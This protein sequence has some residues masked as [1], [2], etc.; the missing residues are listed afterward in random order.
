[1]AATAD[2]GADDR[3]HEMEAARI[4]NSSSLRE[5]VV[6]EELPR[7]VSLSIARSS[8]LKSDL[9]QYHAATD[10]YDLVIRFKGVTV[11]VNSPQQQAQS[12]ETFGRKIVGCFLGP[13]KL[14][15]KKRDQPSSV[16]V[17]DD[18]SGYV[19]PG[20]MT[21]VIGPAGSGKTALLKVLAGH[22]HPSK[23]VKFEGQ[24]LYNDSVLTPDLETKRPIA[25]A[26]GLHNVHLPVLTIRETLEFA[27]KCTRR[28][29]PQELTAQMIRC[30]APDLADSDN[31]FLEYVLQTFGLKQ[32]E[33]LVV[34]PLLKES[35][36]ARLTTA[37][38][39]MRTFSVFLYD[40]P[41]TA[42]DSLRLYDRLHNLLDTVIRVQECALVTC[43][44]Q[45]APEV[46]ELFDR[47]II[48]SEGQMIYQGP[49]HGVENYFFKL[50]YKKPS[51]VDPAVFLQD[52][53]AG[54]GARYLMPGFTKLGIPELVV[55]YKASDHFKDVMRIV[56][57]KD[58]THTYMAETI[59]DIEISI[60]HD[61][62]NG[63]G[64]YVTNV[65][66]AG[67]IITNGAVRVGD[68]ITAVVL[69]DGSTHYVRGGS[70]AEQAAQACKVA[71]LL[72]SREGS[73]HVQLERKMQEKETG[74]C[75]K[76]R[77]GFVN[78]KD[79]LW[80]T[81]CLVKRQFTFA[82]RFKILIILRLFQITVLGL[83]AG[84]FFYK[85]GGKIDQYEMIALRTLGFV[86]MMV[87]ML[88]NLTQLP[89]H[90][91]I[92]RPVFQK[93]R[94]L[95]FFPVSS[96][97]VAHG[98]VSLPQSLLEAII[99]SMCTYFLAGLS[100]ENAAHYFQY[101]ALI[102]VIGYMGSSFVFLVGGFAPLLENAAALAGLF[103]LVC[104][105]FSGVILLPSV[106]PAYWKWML[107]IVP[108]RWGNIIYSST[109]MKTRYDQPCTSHLNFQFCLVNPRL[110]L[111]RAFIKFYDLE[112]SGGRLVLAYAA[113]V[114][115]ILALNFLAYLAYKKSRLPELAPSPVRK[116]QLHPVADEEAVKP[117]P[118]ELSRVEDGSL[119]DGPGQEEAAK[120]MELHLP[121]RPLV[122]TFFDIT[123][124][125]GH[126]SL[127]SG[128][129]KPGQMLAL[130]GS[131]RAG[132]S[133]LLKC[134][135]GRMPSEGEVLVNGVRLKKT[136]FH[137]ISGFA[138]NVEMH[139][140]YLTVRESLE[141]S[142]NL[143]LRRHISSADKARHVD[144]ILELTGL[145]HVSNKLVGVFQQINK[146]PREITKKLTIAIELAANPSILFLD[147][148]TS[149]L[150]GASA[151]NVLHLL[152]TVAMNGRTL[153]VTLHH[154]SAET[155][156]LF[157]SVLVLREG[158]QVYFGPPGTNGSQLLDY[159]TAI[160][161]VP[162]YDPRRSPMVFLLDILGGG[163]TKREPAAD[164]VS[165]YHNSPL[166]LANAAELQSLRDQKDDGLHHLNSRYIAPYKTQFAMVFLRNAR[167]LWR[168]VRYTFN[169]LTG[170]VIIAL[171]IGTL[172]LNIDVERSTSMQSAS[173]IMYIE[174]ILICATTA[175]NLIP[176]L[177]TDRQVYVRESRAR[178]YT[179][180][181]YP[182]SWLVSEIPYILLG[183]F[184]FVGIA[185]G[186]AGVGVDTFTMFL[187]YWT[188]LFLFTMVVVCYGVFLACAAPIPTIAVTFSSII[189]SMWISSSGVSV[190]RNRIRFYK[191]LYWINPF[192][193][194]INILTPTSFYCDTGT[195]ACL[196]CV[197]RQPCPG[198]HCKRLHDVEQLLTRTNTT[199]PAFVWDRLLATRPIEMSRNHWDYLALCGMALFFAA[200]AV[201]SFKF[202]KHNRA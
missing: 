13:L 62:L 166:Q 15:A 49:R 36:K 37:E 19:M 85:K 22:F 168:N 124:P 148:P 12:Y 187:K 58:V 175:N 178:M 116:G 76:K 8:S 47:I 83:F 73:L 174:A 112:A 53:S 152:Q 90:L 18:V 180:L 55:S 117:D 199:R 60:Q 132:K 32:I 48:L 39:A 94:E 93:H 3:G 171:V 113:I 144:L 164:F 193:Y 56:S 118:E 96:Y 133:T 54:S 150:D 149:Q 34:G 194:T 1:M 81:Q 38:I 125:T 183:T 77:F 189:M 146:R 102:F 80:S 163:T 104:L 68:E 177:G 40:Q 202:L 119:R 52:I 89:I 169:R 141:F 120:W 154:P 33:H 107:Y 11:T 140:P 26:T 182:L 72:N 167:F 67:E 160:P 87:L 23:L 121:V 110:T 64:V 29:R 134:L 185:N 78:V 61:T 51:Y 151:R 109:Q 35:A 98:L 99:Y 157:H 21:L 101:L 41:A 145:S 155:L 186:M 138:E 97:V 130:V 2:D 28:L 100:L 92:H 198:C 10:P 63:P 172:F 135:A 200:L 14:L 195:T 30:F 127:I 106:T 196:S 122:L 114:I 156:G 143:R 197:I 59:S 43:M 165:A 191:W 66:E 139:Q 74:A 170:I 137:R 131:T 6:N 162:P 5:L 86:S 46:F 111:G 7:A 161:G 70:P 181:L 184:V 159:F 176:Q 25:Y 24:V 16:K 82:I 79:W 57:S 44:A 126:L 69:P 95:H 128:Y 129:V 147:D 188:C 4:S 88:I 103:I 42:E 136:C 65:S 20:S 142:A 84:S 50:G 158:K 153:L 27:E 115:F 31:P 105:L 17:L 9:E 190:P 201:T 91:L 45:V 71:D 173:L 123:L 179:S 75:Y 192:Q 108:T